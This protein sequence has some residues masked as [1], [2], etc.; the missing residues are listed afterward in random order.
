MLCAISGYYIVMVTVF[1]RTNI[2]ALLLYSI[3]L[4]YC[5]TAWF[6]S[7]PMRMKQQLQLTQTKMVHFIMK[8]QQDRTQASQNLMH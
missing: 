7:L 6:P 1:T 2:Y 5:I 8:P 3:H 4:D